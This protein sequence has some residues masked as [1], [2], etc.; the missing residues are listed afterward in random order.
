MRGYRSRTNS[1]HVLCH[2]NRSWRSTA[3]TWCADRTDYAR[4]F[5]LEGQGREDPVRPGPLPSGCR[6]CSSVA[7][8]GPTSKNARALRIF[9]AA[10]FQKQTAGFFLRPDDLG[11]VWFSRLSDARPSPRTHSS[12][13]FR[14][15]LEGDTTYLS[16]GT[17]PIKLP[18]ALGTFLRRLRDTAP[19]SDLENNIGIFKGRSAGRH[20]IP[21]AIRGPLARG[22]I[23]LRAA[24]NV[25]LMNLAR[26]LPPSVLAD[27]H[28]CRGT[29]ERP[30]WTLLDR[31]PPSPPHDRAAVDIN[32]ELPALHRSEARNY[33]WPRKPHRPA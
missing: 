17:E 13:T 32:T 5:P 33:G 7:E 26:D 16:L 1:W 31:L 15:P 29:L 10:C 4:A 28:L 23:N 6:P 14:G 27:L 3:V 11:V 25:A 30:P 20:V 24:R 21:A 9:R 2:L 12:L 22:G 8:T 19:A 18:A